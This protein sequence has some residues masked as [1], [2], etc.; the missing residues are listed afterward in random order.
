[1]GTAASF[2]FF[3]PE[4]ALGVALLAVIFADLL[5]AGRGRR[6]EWPA[7]ITMVAAATAIVFSVGLPP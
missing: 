7:T 4:L 1:M 6:G 2:R 3:G 5:S